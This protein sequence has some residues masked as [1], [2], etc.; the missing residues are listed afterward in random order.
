MKK[1]IF[2]ILIWVVG[3][4]VG[5][6]ICAS[7]NANNKYA[8]KNPTEQ[9]E[10][11]A[12]TQQTEPPAQETPPP[13]ICKKNGKVLASFVANGV[14]Y[15]RFSAYSPCAASVPFAYFLLDNGDVVIVY[16]S[17]PSTHS[18][19]AYCEPPFTKEVAKIILEAQLNKQPSV[20]YR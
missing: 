4:F 13:P 15:F 10:S 17:T 12:T 11:V 16:P 5:A 7:C 20:V 6:Y 3:F 2:I 8:N 9:T 18:R 14:W 19:E 1:T